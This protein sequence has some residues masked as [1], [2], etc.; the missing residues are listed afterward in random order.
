MEMTREFAKAANLIQSGTRVCAFT[1]AGI[2][3]ESGIPAFRG[4]DGIWNRY[5]PRLLEIGYFLANPSQSWQ[6]IRE[7]FYDSFLGAKPNA[8]HLALSA[9]EAAGLLHCVITQNIDHLHSLAGSK[10]VWEFHGNS[11][12][13]ICLRCSA[14][15]AVADIDLNRIPPVCKKCG[16]LLKPDFVFFGEPIPEPTAGESFR[17]A[18]RSDVFLLIGTTG[19]VMPACTIPR[20]AK[21]NG[22]S[23]IEIN[24]SPSEF[25]GEIT[26]LFIET[27]ATIAMA[28][29][30]HAL[31]IPSR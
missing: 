11:Q 25:T 5:D 23:I 31:G 6:A 17:E 19:E 7:I 27:Q 28:G 29:I 13:L 3:V 16:G 21:E 20:M 4:A 1:G 26:D 15:Y 18:Q 14:S 10:A 30:L 2:S 8:A 12:R 22:A 24:P 9:M